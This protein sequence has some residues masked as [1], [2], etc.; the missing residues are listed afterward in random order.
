M[1]IIV[2]K[3]KKITKPIYMHLTGTRMNA[4]STDQKHPSHVIEGYFSDTES[5]MLIVLQ[6]K[7]KR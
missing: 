7:R 6:H 4:S 3:I 1:S 5:N 2:E